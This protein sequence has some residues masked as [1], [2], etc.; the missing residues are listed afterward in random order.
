MLRLIHA[1]SPSLSLFFSFVLLLLIL[2]TAYDLTMR[3]QNREFLLRSRISSRTNFSIFPRA[4]T[5][6]A[7]VCCFVDLPSLGKQR[8]LFS[9]FSVY[10]NGLKLFETNQA[11]TDD[12]IGCLHGIRALSIM[13]IVHGH[14]VQTYFTFPIINKVQFREV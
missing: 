14:R 13:W 5:M 12:V 3:N 9:A 10:T 8:L 7:K 11:P 1:I 2:S 4:P 6:T